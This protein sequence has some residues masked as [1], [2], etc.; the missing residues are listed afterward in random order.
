MA[1]HHPPSNVP[2]SGPGGSQRGL[3]LVGGPR[4]FLRPHHFA[5]HSPLRPA[6]PPFQ[7]LQRLQVRFRRLDNGFGDSLRV[8]QVT[9]LPARSTS[10]HN[11]AAASV[12][13]V[14]M[15]S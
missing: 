14:V 6:E 3:V 10:G 8:A 9:C 5:H 11:E 15:Q 13:V 7:L 4:T 1:L 12:Q 2:C